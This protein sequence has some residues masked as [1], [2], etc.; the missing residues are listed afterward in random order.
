MAPGRIAPLLDGALI[1]RATDRRRPLLERATVSVLRYI[2]EVALVRP[3]VSPVAERG[4]LEL[5]CIA[6]WFASDV[7]C[8]VFFL[9]ARLIAYRACLTIIKK[10]EVGCWLTSY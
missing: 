5:M 2:R 8:I 9:Q 6:I 1:V 3:N 4:G 10:S 7:Y